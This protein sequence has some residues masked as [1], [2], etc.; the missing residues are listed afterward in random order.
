MYET[1]Y[2]LKEKPF[3]LIPDPDYLFLGRLHGS[4]LNILEYGLRGEASFTLITGEVGCGK[5]IV[6]RKFLRMVDESAAVG[7]VTNTPRSKTHILERILLAFKLDYR[8][9]SEIE[10]YE[11]LTDFVEAQQS[12][13]RRTVLIIDEAHNI[14]EDSLEE[15]R[16]LSNINVDKLLAL[17]IVLVGQ[18][19]I[20]DLLNTRS[21]RQLTQRISVHFKLLSLSFA[22]TRRYIRHRMIV[23]GGSP[24][25]FET[26]AIAVIH[27]L[28]GG[29]PRLIN[30]LCDAALVYGFGADQGTLDTRLVQMVA[31]DMLQDGLQTLPGFD[32]DIEWEGVLEAAD[33]LVSSLDPDELD[34]RHGELPPL[35]ASRRA[36]SSPTSEAKTSQPGSMEFARK[37]HN[38]KDDGAGEGTGVHRNVN[39]IYETSP[40]KQDGARNSRLI[41]I[42]ALLA[43]FAVI[44]GGLLW[45]YWPSAERL[46]AFLADGPPR[47]QISP[48][49]LAAANTDST[50]PGSPQET[51]VGQEES[52][53]IPQPVPTNFGEAIQNDPGPAENP[54]ETTAPA[55]SNGAASATLTLRDALVRSGEGADYFG[56]A[57][58]DMFG[59]WNRDLSSL[60]GTAPC[61]R[62]SSAGLSC[63][64]REGNLTRLIGLNRPA[65]IG[66][67]GAGRRTVY[68][69]LVGYENNTVRLKI[70]NY[71]IIA[72]RDEVNALMAGPFLMLWKPP[73]GYRGLLVPGMRGETIEWVR[74]ELKRILGREVGVASTGLFD[75]EL[76]RA[77]RE[78]Q[79]RNALKVD[80][81]VGVETLIKINSVALGGEVPRLDRSASR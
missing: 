34:Q 37:N 4:A 55:P 21:L 76:A 5:T 71:E 77:V 61:G 51:P 73:P 18:P 68:A 25:I 35:S 9:K 50:A 67:Q 12:S 23:A 2:G 11:M 70:D 54:V 65:I 58:A 15:L 13:G 10:Q 42:L 14:D 19:E 52:P 56:A 6:V 17:Q 60:A 33:E 39:P 26:R 53:I 46:G 7:M 28:S 69:L 22:E 3:S 31:N 29:V 8:G 66:I 62:A 1:F 80:G 36:N 72:A 32:R 47:G 63:Y 38:D 27:L 64:E 79:T 41:L 43:A 24:D 30:V 81:I 75:A 44:G 49:Q 57:L 40:E 74:T 45:F 59:L 78:F 20:L 16:M 48:S